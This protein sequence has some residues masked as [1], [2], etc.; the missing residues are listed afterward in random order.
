MDFRRKL[1]RRHAKSHLRAE[2]LL[3]REQLQ[4]TDLAVHARNIQLLNVPRTVGILDERGYM[5]LDLQKHTYWFDRG[6]QQRLWVKSWIEKWLD[7]PTPPYESKHL[8]HT[9]GSIEQIVQVSDGWYMRS[10]INTAIHRWNSIDPKCRDQV[11]QAT[12]DVLD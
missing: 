9:V 3:I 12:K 10:F 4:N 8:D 1:S 11:Y 5:I 6:F 7:I 2:Q